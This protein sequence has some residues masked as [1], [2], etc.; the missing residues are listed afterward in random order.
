MAKRK[1]RSKPSLQR[2]LQANGVAIGALV[3]GLGAIA[4]A[5]LWRRRGTA[6]ERAG[7]VDQQAAMSGPAHVPTDLMGDRHPGPN[8]RAIDAFRPDPTAPVPLAE[9]EAL[10]PATA[11]PTLAGQTPELAQLGG[12]AR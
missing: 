11:A 4:G 2:T 10:R 5:L 1:N 12:D 8:D 6:P 9:R 7:V 3:A